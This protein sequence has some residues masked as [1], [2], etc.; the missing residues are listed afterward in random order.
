MKELLVATGNVHKV[1]EIREILVGTGWE[2]VTPGE[3]AIRA[4]LAPPPEVVEDGATFETNAEKKARVLCGWAGRPA[5]A[6]DSGIEIDALGGAPG[7]LSARFSGVSG[8]GTDEAN[9]RRMVE[10]L[11]DV[12]E[13]ERTGR[14]RCALVLVS[15]SGAVRRADG[16]CEGRISLLAR[17]DGGFGYDPHFLVEGDAR[18]RTMAELAADEKHGISH[19]GQALRNLLPLLADFL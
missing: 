15:P 12:P 10:L 18:G 7:V 2:V 14:Y 4:G 5:L 16:A 6:D 11:I 19:R 3:W 8:P 9:N 1:R 13:E 17:G